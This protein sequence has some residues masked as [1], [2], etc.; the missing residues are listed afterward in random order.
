MDRINGMFTI[1]EPPAK[2]EFVLSCMDGEIRWIG[3]IDE[4]D[5][6]ES[7]AEDAE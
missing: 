6:E 1:P 5:L 7:K 3:V 4:Q 2:G